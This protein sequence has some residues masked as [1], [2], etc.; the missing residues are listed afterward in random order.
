MKDI[1]LFT[2]KLITPNSSKE[3]DDIYIATVETTDGQMGFM[4]NHVNFLTN[5]TNST[6]KI[7][8]K[9]SSET[10]VKIAGGIAEFSCNKLFIIT[11][12]FSKD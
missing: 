6:V 5:L 9:N 10:K 8:N 11:D 7:V 2:V 4:A 12:E 1:D 3:Y